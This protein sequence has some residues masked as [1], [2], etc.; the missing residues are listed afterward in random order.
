MAII[1]SSRKFEGG[2][3]SPNAF[4]TLLKPGTLFVNFREEQNKLGVKVFI[5]GAYKADRSGE[6]MWYKVVKVR[7]NF[8]LDVKEKF[9]VQPGCPVQWFESK[10]KTYAPNYA[11]TTEAIK[12]GLKQKVYPP[13]GRTSYRVLF[14][15]AYVNALGSGAHVLEL[16]Q[17][18]CAD[19][20]DNWC[21][22]PDRPMINNWEASIPV[23]LRIDRKG[24]FPQWEVI[25]DASKS[26]KLPAELADSDYLHDL[27][28]VVLYPNKQELFEKLRMITPGEIFDRCM[29]D[30]KD[31][32]VSCSI[33]SPVSVG[34]Y[35][36]QEDDVPM[37][38]TQAV[39]RP[40]RAQP[41]SPAAA[42][43]ATAP[44][45]TGVVAPAFSI[46]KVTRQAAVLAVPVSEYAD[47]DECPPAPT[48]STP[49]IVNKAGAMAFLRK[50]QA[51]AQ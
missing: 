38:V 35:V 50:P 42:P 23:N 20:I 3:M 48:L 10:V 7:D 1:Q 45:K 9:A 29:V 16:P 25:I 47:N 8:G 31:E 28:S 32:A 15:A 34:G 12:N 49:L 36:E 39:P 26:F 2:D 22:D 27:D 18:K 33:P 41:M 40:S 14:N 17:W 6:G 37:P 24:G 5:L 44:A 51:A 43:A 19:Q 30:Y 21:K 11:A 4:G 46:P 13:H